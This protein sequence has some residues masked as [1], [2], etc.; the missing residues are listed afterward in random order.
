M[1]RLKYTA[2]QNSRQANPGAQFT[3]PTRDWSVDLGDKTETVVRL[4]AVPRKITFNPLE[5]VLAEVKTE[6]W[7]T[8]Q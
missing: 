2:L 1:S 5:S 3:D 7:T 6:P 8:D 4:P